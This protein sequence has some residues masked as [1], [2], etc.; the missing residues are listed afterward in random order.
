MGGKS[1]KR[2]TSGASVQE[3]LSPPTTTTTTNTRNR[4]RSRSGSV[5]KRSSMNSSSSQEALEEQVRHWMPWVW[6]QAMCPSAGTVR[7]SFLDGTIEGFSLLVASLNR[8]RQLDHLIATTKTMVPKSPEGGASSS[9]QQQ[10]LLER[11]AESHYSALHWAIYRA[12]LPSLLFLLHH[13][14]IEPPH[15][16]Q[17]LQS[18]TATNLTLRPMT[19]LE[20][21][22]GDSP[23]CSNGGTTSPLSKKKNVSSSP[24][25]SSNPLTL[26]QTMVTARDAEGFTPGQL[27]AALQ[28]SE[29][30]A[31]RAAL[32]FK[33]PRG[34][35]P[36]AA[37]A[38]APVSL[39][40]SSSVSSS[41][42]SSLNHNSDDRAIGSQSEWNVLQQHVQV[43][44]SEEEDLASASIEEGS[45]TNKSGTEYG[46][47]VLTF[48][49]AHHCALG[50]GTDGASTTTTTTTTTKTISNHKNPTSSTVT[51][52]TTTF[53]PQRVQ[54]FA[55]SEVGRDLSAVAVAAA[56]HH[57]LVLN[58]AGQLYAFGLGKGGRLGIGNHE[59]HSPLPALVD[60]PLRKCRVLAIAAAENHSL[61][62]VQGGQTYA[63]GSNRF[64][65]LGI[66]ISPTTTTSGSMQH[67]K[68]QSAQT[69]SSSCSSSFVPRRI[70]DLKDVNIRA[71][72]AGERHSVALSWSGSI[73]VWGDN[74][75]GQLG[76]P[77]RHGGGGGKG[78]SVKSQKHHAHSA[79]SSSHNPVQCIPHPVLAAQTAVAIAASEYA[80]LALTLPDQS[81]RNSLPVNA[82]YSWGHGNH[83]PSRVHLPKY[84]QQQSEHEANGGRQRRRSRSESWNEDESMKYEHK[85][86]VC[87]VAIACAKYH[88]VAITQNGLVYSWGLHSETLGNSSQPSSSSSSPA[89]CG[90][91]TSPQ[92]VTGM[93]PENGGGWAVTVSASENHTAVVTDTGALYTWGATYGPSILG[94]EGVRWQPDPKR[95][96]GLYRAVAV[97]AAKEHFAVLSGTSFPPIPALSRTLST[98]PLRA[99]NKDESDGKPFAKSS[100]KPS[101]M[102][103]EEMA[104]RQ[105]AKHVD[106]FNVWPILIT[107][108]RIQNET[109]INYCQEFCKRNLDGVLNVGQRRVMACY[110][111]EKQQSLTE[112]RRYD[113][114]MHEM[115]EAQMDARDA[116]RHPVLN[117][118]CHK[119]SCKRHHDAEN[120]TDSSDVNGWMLSCANLMQSGPGQ[121]FLQK[122]RTLENQQ[123]AQHYVYPPMSYAANCKHD[124]Q[125][126]KK[127]SVDATECLTPTT[128]AATPTMKSKRGVS[129][130]EDNVVSVPPQGSARCL[131]LTRSLLDGKD[132]EAESVEDQMKWLQ[133]RQTA[134]LK[135]IRAIR[136][137]LN[138]ITRLVEMESQSINEVE[139][140]NI[141]QGRLSTEQREKVA[142]RALLQTDLS[143]LEPALSDINAQLHKLQQQQT[144][145]PPL[146]TNGD[147][148]MEPLPTEEANSCVLAST[149]KQKTVSIRCELCGVTCSDASSYS[150]HMSGRKHRN[151]VLQLEQEE[152][153]RKAALVL[154][155]QH[156]RELLKQS[157]TSTA[158]PVQRRSTK[159]AAP[160]PW[161]TSTATVSP[162]PQ[163]MYKLPPPPHGVPSAL[164]VT[165]SKKTAPSCSLLDIMAAEEKTQRSCTLEGDLASS[166]RKK[167]TSAGAA[168]SKAASTTK[169]G[170]N[171]RVA[172]L[173]CSTGWVLAS[174]ATAGPTKKH[175]SSALSGCGEASWL[176]VDSLPTL[177]SPPWA[178]APVVS[179]TAVDQNHAR[180]SFGETMTANLSSSS[181]SLGDFLP[182][183][184]KA[185]GSVN[186]LA[187]RR[188]VNGSSPSS[189]IQKQPAWSTP[190]KAGK[191][192]TGNGTAAS[193]A[194]GTTTKF[195]HIQDQE[196]AFKE[197]E[198]AACKDTQAVWFVQRRERAGSLKEIQ[199]SAEKER[200]QRLF[201]EEQHR[202]EKMIFEEQK[203]QQRELEKQ[204][205]DSKNK[206]KRSPN[207][208]R[209]KQG[210]G[211][212]RRGGKVES[213][214]AEKG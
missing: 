59:R 44:W 24:T 23:Q 113:S 214:T 94:H 48:G 163:P 69:T 104:A 184:P 90:Q 115:E 86:L 73:Y 161:K 135:E 124:S 16:R 72:A 31:C 133:D 18:S 179:S 142:R 108:E 89:S 187:G 194:T 82:I 168:M 210:G 208:R 22:G 154:A 132:K 77:P 166:T 192:S 28:Q 99:S 13:A 121:L 116:S 167:K 140:G 45:P 20:Y 79:C 176:K 156:Q 128:T 37:A 151:R 58:R 136:K 122:L 41:Q 43:L 46:C 11:D 39:S 178:S 92:L 137:R 83:V 155:E 38:A 40:S 170:S 119:A 193:P 211:G 118:F 191:Q 112:C 6:K 126:K 66:S 177:E 148:V 138:Q 19:M 131:E 199:R 80:T 196:M 54:A 7:S 164:S 96:P 26:W 84:P 134:L 125:N 65:Q 15:E 213:T 169:V 32:T 102:S 14:A 150:L 57:T 71:V 5:T 190:H 17:G 10:L 50:V 146:S 4:A 2:S 117:E 149:A 30:R 162:I 47:E 62:V 185:T 34:S 52:T 97:A 171:T 29:L 27:L 61:A 207:K 107:A 1:R 188:E 172:S 186:G 101:I 35:V 209:G 63:W 85:R 110:L 87:P 123:K 21:T 143:I 25:V 160:N 204:Q 60:F 68:K 109:L 75:S 195:V 3:L 144:K 8:A 158:S 180:T 111:K 127:S 105:V 173:P 114:E 147:E 64:G 205:E 159:S 203:Q 78:H 81:K 165:K 12:D 206:K 157:T 197:K 9:L 51:S 175:S 182:S 36:I 153:D 91:R 139:G 130:G 53:R 98:E 152:Q 42:E 198:D 212:T 55:Q 141:Q 67:H 100:T 74:S 95:V 120:N 181:Y 174:P 183:K 33:M 56:A 145:N 129:F 189:R 200:E 88:N 201:V 76:V 49:R 202:I 93:L 106:L 103:L 70:D